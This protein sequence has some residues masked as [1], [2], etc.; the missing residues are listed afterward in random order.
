MIKIR[1]GLE[2]SNTG[3]D[4][5]RRSWTSFKRK[6]VSNIMKYMSIKCCINGEFSP[7]A[8]QKRFVVRTPASQ[9]KR[10][11]N[12]KKRVQKALIALKNNWN[13][14]TR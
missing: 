2:D 6:P 1:K 3:W 9:R 4:F 14:G 5:R 8:P 12:L 7:K 13:I 10:K 11:R